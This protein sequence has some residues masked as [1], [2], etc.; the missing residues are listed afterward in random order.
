MLIKREDRVVFERSAGGL[1][2]FVKPPIRSPC[3]FHFRRAYV[4]EFL[5]SA[6]VRLV[7]VVSGRTSCLPYNHPTHSAAVPIEVPIEPT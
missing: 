2:P 3:H 6:L 5:Y 7:G 1:N 4:F